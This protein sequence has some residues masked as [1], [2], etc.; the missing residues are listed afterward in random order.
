MEA[1][2]SGQMIRECSG[3]MVILGEKKKSLKENFR[4]NDSV[5]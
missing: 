5:L 2:W 3:E 1:Q 4:K